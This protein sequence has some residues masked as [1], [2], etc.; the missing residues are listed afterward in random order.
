M[1]ENNRKDIYDERID[2][3][4]ISLISQR[5]KVGIIG[6]G[7]AGTIKAKHFVR[8]KCYIEVLAKTFSEELIEL[9]K[10]NREKIK[11]IQDEFKDEFLKDKHLI[12]IALDNKEL[13]DKIKNYCE[14]NYKIYIDCSDFKNGMGV[15]PIQRNTKN[16][17]FALNTRYG[18]P[19]GSVLLLNK[20]TNLLEEYDGFIEYVGK[21]RNKA[22]KLTAY[23]NEII[24]LINEDEFKKAFD[25]G[26]CESVLRDNF[27]KEIVDKLY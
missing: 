9:S 17:T 19:K 21:I 23:K 2:Y 15:V 3:S 16:I 13:I 11:L 10:E 14:K 1:D 26:K 7:K 4:Y 18:N 20:V 25:D 12:I 8:D 27:P 24:K 22:I 5:L 6:A